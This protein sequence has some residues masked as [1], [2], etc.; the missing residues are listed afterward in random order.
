M[1]VGS[2]LLGMNA[3]KQEMQPILLLGN[4]LTKEQISRTG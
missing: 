3:H 2:D 1:K 4:K